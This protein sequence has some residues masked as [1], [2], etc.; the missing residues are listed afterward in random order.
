V[1]W[2]PNQTFEK[3]AASLAR[4]MTHD[5]TW[6]SDQLRP[7]A[8]TDGVP[9]PAGLDAAQQKTLDQLTRTPAAQFDAAYLSVAQSG[10]T[11]ALDRI[12]DEMGS[13]GNPGL[14][15]FVDAALPIA[16]HD[17]DMTAEKLPTVKA[18]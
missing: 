15:S 3:P 8:V 17:Q 7:L 14:R 1:V 5:W 2:K 12:E 18:G 6:I 9:V 11:M 10:A 13:S 4:K 16:E